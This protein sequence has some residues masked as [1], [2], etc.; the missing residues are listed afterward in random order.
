MFRLSGD[1]A[2]LGHFFCAADNIR[3]LGYL[4]ESLRT[5]ALLE[6]MRDRAWRAVVAS[7]G[8]GR[9]ASDHAFVNRIEFD[10]MLF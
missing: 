5:S 10:E 1:Q 6:S 3:P 2:D 8:G 9:G 7:G 4:D